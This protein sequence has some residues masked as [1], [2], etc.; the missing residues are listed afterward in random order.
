MIYTVGEMAKKI[1]VAPSTLRYYD[2]EGLLPFIERSEGGIRLFN[3]RDFSYLS[4]IHC[5][6]QTGMPI[7]EIKNFID[8]VSKGDDSIPQRLELF[9][10]Q[11]ESVT[12][13]IKKLQKTLDILDYKCLYYETSSEKGSTS[14]VEN[15]SLE[16]M[17]EK[18][19]TIRKN[20]DNL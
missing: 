10:N 15:M 3:D 1:N 11:R 6:K 5:L 17:P 4:I 13:Q 12:S 20:M 14:Y 7:K 9:K 16:E 2:K 8:L 18:Y 19:A